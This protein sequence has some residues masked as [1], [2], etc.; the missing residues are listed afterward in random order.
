MTE[1]A[2]LGRCPDCGGE[3]PAGCRLIEYETGDGE[4]AVW[5]ECPGCE[6]VVAPE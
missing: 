5:A 6:A 1:N 4:S 2:L 3:V